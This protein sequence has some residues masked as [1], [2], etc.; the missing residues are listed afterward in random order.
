MTTYDK[1]VEDD[2]TAKTRLMDDA[3]DLKIKMK[4]G[5]TADVV[6]TRKPLGAQVETSESTTKKREMMD[7]SNTDV[8]FSVGLYLRAQHGVE[9]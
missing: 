8:T 2:V 7:V 3:E 1:C 6:S 4:E 9:P 5:L